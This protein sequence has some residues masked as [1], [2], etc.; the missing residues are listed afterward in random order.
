LQQITPSPTTMPTQTNTLP[1]PSLELKDI[2]LP[3]QITNYPIAYGWWLLATIVIMTTLFFL[4]KARQKAKLKKNQQLALKQLKNAPHMSTNDILSLLKWAAMQYFS[5]VQLAKLYGEQFQQFLIQKLSEKHQQKFTQ[6]SKQ[7]FV[8]QYHKANNNDALNIINK[9]LHQAA[10]L[11]LTHA[12]PPKVTKEKTP[13]TK[14]RL[15]ANE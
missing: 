14:Q 13:T 7:A 2:H 12:L 9:D 11:W 5:R 4:Y 1:A 15:G 8:E 10:I 3:E 6:L